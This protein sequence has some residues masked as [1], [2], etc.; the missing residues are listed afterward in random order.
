MLSKQLSWIRACGG[1][2]LVVLIVA[3]LLLPTKWEE[4]RTGHWAVEHFLA[5]FAAMC[6]LC[7][8]WRRPWVVAVGLIALAALLEALQSLNP[9]HAPNV[10]AALSSI[11]GVL[12]ASPLAV[13]LIGV[14]DV[15]ASSK[16]TARAA[17]DSP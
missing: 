12:A 15:Q 4:L 7:L 13:F 6:I 1:V 2:A 14:R 10:L 9:D 11:G 5:Y 17:A 3:S 16:G 8:G